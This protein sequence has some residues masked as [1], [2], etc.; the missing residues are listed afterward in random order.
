MRFTF[1]EIHDLADAQRNFE[2]LEGLWG[3]L[4]N[5]A[6]TPTISIWAVIGVP[7]NSQGTNGDLAVRKDGGAMTTIYQKRTGTWTAIL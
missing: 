7:P 6:G 1:R 2:Q 4:S 3:T 5:F